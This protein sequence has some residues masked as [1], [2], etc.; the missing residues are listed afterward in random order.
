MVGQSVGDSILRIK[1]GG[2][3]PYERQAMEADAEYRR[4]IEAELMSQG[5]V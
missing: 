3:T 5:L 1:G 2:V 4:Q